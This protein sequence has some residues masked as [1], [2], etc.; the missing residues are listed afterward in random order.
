MSQENKKITT[1][2]NH[3]IKKFEEKKTKTKAKF[4]QHLNH[5]QGG[6]IQFNSILF[7]IMTFKLQD[8]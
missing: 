1:I 2:L 8:Q 4:H 7:L 5:C 6:N 3:Y